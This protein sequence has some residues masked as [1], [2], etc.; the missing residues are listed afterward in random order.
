MSECN[1]ANQSY[2]LDNL[3]IEHVFVCTICGKEI[4]RIHEREVRTQ[5]DPRYDLKTGLLPGVL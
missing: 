4:W 2:Y 5:P 3:T 1:H